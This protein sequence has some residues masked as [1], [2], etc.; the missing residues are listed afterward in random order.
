MKFSEIIT[1]L[2]ETTIYGV[3]FCLVIVSMPYLVGK[4][5]DKIMGNMHPN[6]RA[7]NITPL[8]TETLTHAPLNDDTDKFLDDTGRPSTLLSNTTQNTT[9]KI[10]YDDK[11]NIGPGNV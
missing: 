1:N 9:N 6:T 11:P 2:I 7:L 10:T 4:V 8:G 3:P 5:M